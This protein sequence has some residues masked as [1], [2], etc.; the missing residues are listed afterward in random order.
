MTGIFVSFI[1]RQSAFIS[2]CQ[3]LT[4]DALKL[5]LCLLATVIKA[6]T[7]LQLFFHAKS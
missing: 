5:T 3:L 7:A 4:S 1:S 2:V 6:L